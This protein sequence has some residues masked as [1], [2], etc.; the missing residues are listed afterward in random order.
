MRLLVM[1]VALTLAA[2]GGSSG[3]SQDEGSSLE[4]AKA[5]ALVESIEIVY[6][7]DPQPDWYAYLGSSP[8]VAVR[9]GVAVVATS[10]DAGDEAIAETMCA[11]IAAVTFDDNA[12]PIGIS[13]VV[14]LAGGEAI[15]E[16]ET[17]D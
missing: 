13:D 9:D 11:N 2:C 6:G 7:S 14:I 10:L 1:T 5:A 16:C 12:E 3:Q 15:A 17:P 4:P 8:D